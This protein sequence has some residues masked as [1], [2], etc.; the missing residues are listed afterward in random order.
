MDEEVEVIEGEVIE[1]RVDPYLDAQIRDFEWRLDGLGRTYQQALWWAS[2][3][4]SGAGF[5][6]QRSEERPHAV[7]R[8]ARACGAVLV[9]AGEALIAHSGLE[10]T[11]PEEAGSESGFGFY[12]VPPLSLDFSKKE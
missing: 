10:T 9:M 2:A 7:R 6:D 12:T 5:E 3:Q 11:E 1:P 8:L 4:S